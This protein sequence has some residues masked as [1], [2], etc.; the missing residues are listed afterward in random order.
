MGHSVGWN[1]EKCVGSCGKFAK[2]IHDL[3]FDVIPSQYVTDSFSLRDTFLKR[4]SMQ[5]TGKCLFGTGCVLRA[6]MSFILRGPVSGPA[7]F[8]VRLRKKL[9]GEGDMS[10]AAASSTVLT[11]ESSS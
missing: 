1:V 2:T 4:E 5:K 6:H 9:K 7:S 11:H 3:Q 8:V 10:C